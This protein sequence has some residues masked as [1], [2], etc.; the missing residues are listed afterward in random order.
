MTTVSWQNWL[1]LNPETAHELGVDNNDV[2]KVISPFGEI[3]AAVFLFPGIR[4][5]V[6]AMPIGQGHSDFGRYAKD[7]GS[8]PVDL[9][10]TK[11]GPVVG[12]LSWGANR[13]RIEPTGR[14]YKLAR[15]E[16]IEGEGREAVR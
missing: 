8:N 15:L 1:E 10:G 2:V 13:V 12:T 3:E 6:V 4:P 14:T 9:L 16:N 7:R 5:D 11:N